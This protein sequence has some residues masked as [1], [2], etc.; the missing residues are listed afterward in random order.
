MIPGDVDNPVDS[1]CRYG[2]YRRIVH[3]RRSRRFVL[4]YERHR[5]YGFFDMPEEPN[6][7]KPAK[8]RL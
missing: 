7:R 4:M 5:E 3:N 1:G 8:L 6:E 2:V